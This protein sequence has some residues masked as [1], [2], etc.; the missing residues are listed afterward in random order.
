[1]G[2]TYNGSLALAGNIKVNTS[3]PLDNRQVVDNVNDLT[4]DIF[5]NYAFVGMLV[6]VVATEEHYVLTNTPNTNSSNWKKITS[7]SSQETVEVI[8]I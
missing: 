2:L 7:E 3:A 6:Y 4:S 8:D 5:G 1:M